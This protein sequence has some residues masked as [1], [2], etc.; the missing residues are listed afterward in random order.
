L[1]KLL[2]VDAEFRLKGLITVKDI[3]KIEFPYAAKD[4]Q[5]AAG[6]RRGSAPREIFWS[7][8]SS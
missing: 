3:R 4:S 1:K 7:A 5:A 8:P 2:V 6:G